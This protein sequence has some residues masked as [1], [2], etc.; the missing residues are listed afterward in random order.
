MSE[1]GVYRDDMLRTRISDHDVER[2]LCGESPKDEALAP[3][4][5]IL[6]AFDNVSWPAPTEESLARFASAAAEIA[7]AAQPD[8]E[9]I[10]ARSGSDSRWPRP[11]L[12]R[13][14]ATGLAT[15][16]LV[17]GLSAVAIA[18]DE[19]V[20]GDQLYWLDRALEAVGIGDGG[21][22]ERISEARALF[23]RGQ[24]AEAIEHAAEA[25]VVTAEEGDGT[26]GSS[27]ESV[28]ATEALQAAADKVQEGNDDPQSQDV[29]DAVA[30]ML[31]EM[32]AMLEDPDLEGKNFGQNVAEMARMLG[33]NDTST[34][35][36]EQPPNSD[37]SGPPDNPGPPE[38]PPGNSGGGQ[39]GT[40]GA[41]GQSGETPAD[42]PGRP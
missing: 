22:V 24:V 39:G 30:A 23:E 41:P 19:A 3:L 15:L 14:L 9:A 6:S 28:K 40:D 21:A 8:P 10:A 11:A 36:Q 34:S 18:S 5:P 42:P 7:Q 20:P 4:A 12:Q 29:R 27:P 32:A 16:L 1:S 37:N 33:G 13:G 35:D 2:L 31:S 26:D 25:V 38:D 17:S